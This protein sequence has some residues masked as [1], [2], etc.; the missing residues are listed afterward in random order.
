MP[1]AE[2]PSSA[3]RTAGQ[4]VTCVLGRVGRYGVL[5]RPRNP[6]ACAH[7]TVDERQRRARRSRDAAAL[8]ATYSFRIG[9]AFPADDRDARYVMRLSMA[10]GDLR[11]AA[12]YATRNRQRAAERLYFVRLTASHLRELVILLDPPNAKVIPTVEQFVVGLPRGTQPTRAE[13]RASHREAI[14]RLAAIMRGRPDIEVD[15]KTR[16]PT[17]R[18]DLKELR[19]RFF[20]YG[21]DERGDAALRNAM[22]AVATSRSSY[23]IRDR[24]LR[25]RYA[26]VVGTLL[27]HPYEQRFAPDMHGQIVDLIGPV[28]LYVQQVEAAW[29]WTRKPG[30]VT[31]RKPGGER[32]PLH[33]P[34]QRP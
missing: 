23:V 19:N 30:V 1:L 5:D 31:V 22:D 32:Y 21:H 26:D 7:D 29:I 18:D 20:H 17:L 16:A 12:H 2:R 3:R 34:A 10:L 11:I 9:D 24:T 33:V 25:A 27:A 4:S 14:R 15:G 28:A 8:R 6:D 13:I